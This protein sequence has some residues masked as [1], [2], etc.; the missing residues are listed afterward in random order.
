MAL[1]FDPVVREAFQREMVQ[2]LKE[3][4]L[5]I[6]PEAAAGF[7]VDFLKKQKQILKQKHATPY[8]IS[9]Y[10]LLP[11][12]PTQQTIKNM[13]ADGR[14]TKHEH[15]EDSDGKLQILITAI[16]RLTK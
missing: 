7:A 4:G 13:V 16:K 6:V 5:M 12:A 15:F 3:E 9:K 10:K 14:I 1:E 8:M 11:G 2:C